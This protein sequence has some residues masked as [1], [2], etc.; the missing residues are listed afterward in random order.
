MSNVQ[1]FR[2]GVR[3]VPL[4]H[5]AWVV[6]VSDDLRATGKRPAFG[7][8]SQQR[9]A[10]G[11]QTGLIPFHQD[12]HLCVVQ[13]IPLHLLLSGSILLLPIICG[14]ICVGRKSYPFSLFCLIGM[15]SV[16]RRKLSFTHTCP[17]RSEREHRRITAANARQSQDSSG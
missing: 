9:E 3:L 15:C 6:L 11:K 7:S 10:Q 2:A 16:C 12:F 5:W 4:C 13:F 17:D 1:T 14:E 8:A